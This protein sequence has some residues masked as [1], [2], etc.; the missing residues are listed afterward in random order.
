[1]ANF[2]DFKFDWS[3]VTAI[4]TDTLSGQFL[5][6]A[7]T[8]K[9]GT[10]LLKKVSAHDLTQVYFSVPLSVTAITNLFILGTN[11]YASVT[12]STYAL[13]SL[14]LSAPFTTQNAWTKTELGIA[15]EF[16]AGALGASDLYLLTPGILSGEYARIVSINSGG[17]F[18]E[19]IDLQKDLITVLDAVSVTVDS[20][21]D[22]WVVDS[23]SPTHLFRIYSESGAWKIEE[24]ILS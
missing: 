1:M 5:W 15:E 23:Q 8:L 17:S 24:N 9:N 4:A 7:Y 6:I 16:C 19:T 2:R 13:Y 18:I 14:S 10:C 22:L 21:D 11:I 12:H 20:N 3:Q